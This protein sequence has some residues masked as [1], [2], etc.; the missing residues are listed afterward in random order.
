[1]RFFVMIRGTKTGYSADV[2]DLLGCVATAKTLKSVKKRIAK[3]IE[4]HLD[5]MQQSGEKLPTP[6]ERVE[7]VIDP[8]EKEE[9]C[10]WVEVPVTQPA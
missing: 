10:T 2:P 5:L 7:F 8:A 1:M 9:L 3:A 4:L 6:S